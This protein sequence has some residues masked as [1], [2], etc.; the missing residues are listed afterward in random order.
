MI[1]I[2]PNCRPKESSVVTPLFDLNLPDDSTRLSSNI[3]ELHSGTIFHCNRHRNRSFCSHQGRKSGSNYKNQLPLLGSPKFFQR[4]YARTLSRRA[5][6][7]FVDKR[8]IF[9]ALDS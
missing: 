7:C 6:A 1:P 8:P 3:P 4:T 5:S 2:S 9:S